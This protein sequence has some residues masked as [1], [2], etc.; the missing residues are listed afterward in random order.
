MGG[1]ARSRA[2]HRA[3]SG[4]DFRATSQHVDLDRYGGVVLPEQAATALGLSVLGASV[5]TGGGG[6]AGAL[7]K[8]SD[9]YDDCGV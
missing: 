9:R 4:R 1:G 3:V 7:D 6:D 8:C 5:P 2:A